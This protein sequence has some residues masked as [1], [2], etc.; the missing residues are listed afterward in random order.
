[1]RSVVKMKIKQLVSTSG[2]MA[3]VPWSFSGQQQEGVP[4][5][6]VDVSYQLTKPCASSKIHGFEKS[7]S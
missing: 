2:K 4:I 6:F 3:A 5:G 7:T 1:M